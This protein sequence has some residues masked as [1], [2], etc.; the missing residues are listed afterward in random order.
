M[1]I[2]KKI[3]YGKDARARLQTGANKVAD[4]VKVTMGPQGR[5]VVIGKKFRVPHITKDGVTV[6]REVILPDP[7]ENLGAQI[8]YGAAKGAH[9]LAGDGTTTATVLAQFLINEGIKAMESGANPVHIKN[10]MEF[11]LKKVLEQLKERSVEIGEDFNKMT[12]IATIAS[13]GD[14]KL[15]AMIADILIKIG[16]SG[17]LDIEKS[18]T[19]ETYTTTVDGMQFDSGHKRY[20]FVTNTSKHITELLNPYILVTDNKISLMKDIV[21]LLESYLE[22]HAEPLVIICE[23]M[24]GEALSTIVANRIERK[25]PIFV[26]QAPEYG[27]K[28]MHAL[29]DICA[30]TGAEFITGGAGM[31]TEEVTIESLGQAKKMIIGMHSTLIMEGAGPDRI[32]YI[33]EIKQLAADMPQDAH[34]QHRMAKLTGGIGVI[35]VGGISEV[36]VEERKDRVDDAVKATRA[37]IAEGVVAGGGIALL[38]IFMGMKELE[39]ANKGEAILGTALQIPFQQIMQ[40]AGHEMTAVFVDYHYSA[41]VAPSEE[42]SNWGYNLKTDRWE[43]LVRAGVVDPTKVVRIALTHAVSIAGMFL[44][45]ECMMVETAE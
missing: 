15:G 11:A 35:Y 19:E 29:R 30:V 3:E 37:A 39:P 1:T 40:N 12:Q 2:S 32:E 24:D 16:V 38:N 36:E 33:E 44:T 22:S 21:G 18:P 6:A 23:D 14:E 8:I 28:R 17:Q 13:N 34:M 4:A 41:H 43:D 10:E 45:C 25:V 26:L 7:M 31:K 42:F 27:E 20:E 9:D 5:N